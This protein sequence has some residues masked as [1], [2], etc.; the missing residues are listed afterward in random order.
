VLARLTEDDLL[1][2]EARQ[3]ADLTDTTATSE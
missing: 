3:G 1:D 2:P